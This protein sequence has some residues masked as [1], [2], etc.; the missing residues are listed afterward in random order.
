MLEGRNRHTAQG[1]SR[2]TAGWSILWA[3]PDRTTKRID[4]QGSDYPS[5]MLPEELS[6]MARLRAWWLEHFAPQEQMKSTLGQS[7]RKLIRLE[8][9]EP[10]RFCDMV[11]EV[12]G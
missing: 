4:G 7:K 3:Q 5:R 8:E 12:S 10:G 6:R 2:R 1:A 11:V 9:G